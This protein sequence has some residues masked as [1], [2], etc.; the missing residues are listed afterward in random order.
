MCVHWQAC[1]PYCVH[2]V[3][4]AAAQVVGDDNVS[5]RIKHELYVV[6]VGGARHVAVDLLGGGFVFCFELRLDVRGC[7]TVFLCPYWQKKKTNYQ[8]V[9]NAVCMDLRPIY[10][11]L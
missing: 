5:D 7:F 8:A 1:V 9:L 11:Y 3:E 10:T 6:G 4:A 2:L